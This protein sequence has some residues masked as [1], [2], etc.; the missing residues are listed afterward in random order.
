MTRGFSTTWCSGNSRGSV[1][2]WALSLLLLP[3]GHQ[4]VAPFVAWRRKMKGLVHLRRTPSRRSTAGCFHSCLVDR[5]RRTHR[6]QERR[7]LLGGTKDWAAVEHS[8]PAYRM[9]DEDYDSRYGA[10]TR[11]VCRSLPRARWEAP[12]YYVLFMYFLVRSPWPR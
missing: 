12:I 4:G 3:H 8:F 7:P 9:T 10:C 11:H 5:E 6:L 1:G 2:Q